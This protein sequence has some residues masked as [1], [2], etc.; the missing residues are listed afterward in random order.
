MTPIQAEVMS[1]YCEKLVSAHSLSYLDSIMKDASEDTDV[2][3]RNYLV[4]VR[5]AKAICVE[6][7]F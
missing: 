6:R 5:L 7:G 3:N 1:R 2:P 4:L